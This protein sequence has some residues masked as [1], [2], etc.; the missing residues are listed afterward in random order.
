[1]GGRNE[2]VVPLAITSPPHLFK[3]LIPDVLMKKSDTVWGCSWLD[4]WRTILLIV[5]SLLMLAFPLTI[6]RVKLGEI[7]KI[8]LYE[9]H[10]LNVE[11]YFGNLFSFYTWKWN[12]L[13]KSLNIIWQMHNWLNFLNS[14]W[15]E[16]CWKWIITFL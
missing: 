9:K 15:Q 11:D 8:R 7:K 16:W 13:D 4:R 6:V 10:F 1:M 2:N 5:T 12:I 3:Y 14:I